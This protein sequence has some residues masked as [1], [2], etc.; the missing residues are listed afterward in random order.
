MVDQVPAL[1]VTEKHVAYI[2][3][4]AHRLMMVETHY[5]VLGRFHSIFYMKHQTLY[6]TSNK[7]G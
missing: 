3:T 4:C 7:E 2:H 5:I 1:Q 6:I